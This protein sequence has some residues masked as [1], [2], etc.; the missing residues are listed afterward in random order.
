MNPLALSLIAAG[1]AAISARWNWWRPHV[2]GL[3]VLMYHQIGAAPTPCKRSLRKLWVE[4]DVFRAQM[5][6][7]LGKGFTP[8]TFS[9]LAAAEA[10][11]SLPPKPALI[12]FDDGYADNYE[13]AFPILRELGV[14]A[15]IFLVESGLDKQNHWHNPE[16]FPWQRMLSWKQVDEM[17][18]SGLV[19]YGSHTVGHRDLQNLELDEARY[20][21]R[22]SKARLERRLGKNILAFAYPYG[23]GAY[24]PQ[25]RALIREAGYQYDFGIRQGI[26]PWPWEPAQGPIQRLL[27]RGGDTPWDFHL[28]ITRGKAR[29]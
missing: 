6:Y 4:A 13:N 8:L 7:L 12:T 28:N 10:Q 20:E 26:T 25:I 2:S 24:S 16:D 18:K 14:P 9:G 5:E 21:I 11:G 19:E 3:V 17:A 29:F 23:S 15:N 1:G 22:E 27:I